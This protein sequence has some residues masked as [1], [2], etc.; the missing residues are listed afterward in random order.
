MVKVVCWN[1][2]GLVSEEKIV[3]VRNLIKEE[4]NHI[5]L[6]QETKLGEWKVLQRSNLLWHNNGIKAVSCK[7]AFRGISTLWFQS[8]FKLIQVEI[9]PH[10][11][12]TKFIHIYFGKTCNIVNICMPLSHQEK[13]H[14]WNSLCSLKHTK[15]GQGNI[16]VGDLKTTLHSW[17]KNGD[18]WLEIS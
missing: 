9:S 2:N 12:A 6:L 16:F 13:F 11:I 18:P 14:C 10:W 4:N 17:E 3:V 8:Y 7:E 1:N 5:I 15:Y